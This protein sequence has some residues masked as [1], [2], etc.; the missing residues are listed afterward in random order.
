MENTQ[1]PE[2]F[3][4]FLR[5]LNENEVRYLLIG[6]YAVGYYGYPRATHDMDIWIAADPENAEKMVGVMME[7]GFEQG[8]V[9]KQV[10]LKSDGVVRLGVPPL[11]LEILMSASGVTFEDCYG[12]GLSDDIDGVSV[13]IIHL[14]DLVANK[15][16]AGRHKDLDDV[17][18][19]PEEWPE[20]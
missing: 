20:T 8:A 18:N 5:L 15:T 11:R 17:S 19:L 1:L 14:D 7:F 4:D 16:A 10:F 6:G 2:D 9:S 13:R 12:R 3:K